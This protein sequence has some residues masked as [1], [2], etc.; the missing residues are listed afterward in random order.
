MHNILK[1]TWQEKGGYPAL[2]YVISGK[3]PPPHVELSTQVEKIWEG[4]DETGD[5]VNVPV[6]TSLPWEHDQEGK[7]YS[8]P[9]EELLAKINA[10]R[11]FIG[12][13]EYNPKAHFWDEYAQ[14][15]STRSQLPFWKH[16]D[17]ILTNTIPI[18]FKWQAK[19]DLYVQERNFRAGLRDW[20]YG[21]AHGEFYPMWEGDDILKFTPDLRNE[22]FLNSKRFTEVRT[23]M[24]LEKLKKTYPKT[25]QEAYIYYKYIAMGKAPNF[26]YVDMIN[27]SVSYDIPRPRPTNDELLKR[28]HELFTDAKDPKEPFG[29][30]PEPTEE[31]IPTALLN[32]EETEEE[33]KMR[34][35]GEE[36]KW[37]EGIKKWWVMEALGKDINNQNPTAGL[38]DWLKKHPFKP[39]TTITAPT[40]SNPSGIQPPV[41]PPAPVTPP[42]PAPAILPATPAPA[43]APTTPKNAP[44]PAPNQPQV[45][46]KSEPTNEQKQLIQDL[47]NW[48]D[49]KAAYEK[50][51]TL[52]QT[53]ISEK[54]R[55]LKEMEQK[56]SEEVNKLQEE[57]GLLVARH[58]KEKGELVAQHTKEKEQLKLLVQQQV[59]KLYHGYI[60]PEDLKKIQLKIEE[61]TRE[62][63][64]KQI[65]DLKGNLSAARSRVTQLEHIEVNQVQLQD[66]NKHL[67][68]SVEHLNAAV[69]KKSKEHDE[70]TEKIKLAAHE[71]QQKE[72]M[73]LSLKN[74]ATEDRKKILQELATAQD[75]ASR[76]AVANKQYEDE[77]E[78]TG[79]QAGKVGEVLS[80]LHGQIEELKK[81]LEEYRKKQ[82]SKEVKI[83]QKGELLSEEIEKL[84]KELQH[85]KWTVEEK[86]DVI[87][88]LRKVRDEGLG[89]VKDL[90]KHL[91]QSVAENV[92]LE[93]I[94]KARD[95]SLEE[96]SKRVLYP[97]EEKRVY[98]TVKKLTEERDL[99]KDINKTLEADKEHLDYQLKWTEGRL[100][101]VGI[102]LED[103]EEEN[104]EGAEYAE[105]VRKKIEAIAKKLANENDQLQDKFVELQQQYEKLGK[106]WKAAYDIEVGQKNDWF[107]KFKTLEEAHFA[108]E[109]EM[110]HL[111][112]NYEYK[113]GE[114]KKQIEELK[115][116][117]EGE[118]ATA[119]QDYEYRKGVLQNKI[120]ELE[121]AHEGEL[122]TA[123][124]DSQYKIEQLKH[125]IQELQ[126]AHEGE[127]AQASQNY[128]FKTGNLK[129]RIKELKT[130]LQVENMDIAE[131][132]EQAEI[133][134]AEINASEDLND[135]LQ[136]ENDELKRQVASLA[137]ALDDQ[138]EKKWNVKSAMEEQGEVETGEINAQEDLIDSLNDQK[139]ALE[140]K[141]KT[142]LDKIDQLEDKIALDRQDTKLDRKVTRPKTPVKKRT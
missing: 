71:I 84:G 96:Q 36:E 73:I 59:Q 14:F 27:N 78:A 63:V 56:K 68:V 125:Q 108:R 37:R 12:L 142:A 120:Q 62:Q 75:K 111:S 5:K 113:T 90:L 44:A 94:I 74:G 137:K 116:A 25:M 31:E 117:H 40:G 92:R 50:E 109:G 115:Y 58:G 81:E 38:D 114:L 110:A 93:G 83:R 118:L 105:H 128:E 131:A 133:D 13:Q 46:Q 2:P 55:L 22:P 140:K 80:I 43:P 30:A 76:L 18:L 136:K 130:R 124:Q 95:K 72:N 54:D 98:E 20:I 112:Q 107:T 141:L 119:S 17:T 24:Y 52:N 106:D 129:N 35:L 101:T 87:G 21:N 135:F 1:S 126:F 100:K 138:R 97:E 102:I 7:L 66:Q 134:N 77:Y 4:L 49:Q 15:A 67:L 123:S 47:K 32:P 8:T 57:K 26:D 19:Y 99:L 42:T 41:L 11:G 69:K 23:S 10:L 33:K 65:S 29:N 34:E 48:K 88:R 103:T 3:P 79:L 53:T 127:L 122:A 51:R 91:A 61:T 70:L 121:Y 45:L 82:F 85:E 132:E 89:K 139:D 16:A 39:K 6:D 9:T 60:S 28:L 64:K 104:L 86:N